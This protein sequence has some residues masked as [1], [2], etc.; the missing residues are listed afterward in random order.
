ML[1]IFCTRACITFSLLTILI[2]V[3][4]QAVEDKLW[5][6]ALNT[7]QQTKGQ[8][9]KGQKLSDISKI[10]VSNCNVQW[11]NKYEIEALKSQASIFEKSYGL[12]LRGGYTTDN[13][14]QSTDNI[15]GSTYLELSWDALKSGYKDY[16]YKAKALKREA[17]IEK[18][19]GQLKQKILKNECRRYLIDSHFSAM[20][21]YLTSLKL[22]FMEDIYQVER[23]AYFKGQSYLDELLI[24]EEDITLA[25]QRLEHINNVSETSVSIDELLN[26]PIINID[27]QKLLNAINEL[28]YFYKVKKLK[29]QQLSDKYAKE[30]SFI[31]NS[32]FRMFIRKE[33]DLARSGEDELVAGI[34]FQT[35]INFYGGK[36]QK[37]ARLNQLESDLNH[38]KWEI[39]TRARS[40]YQSL[41]EQL[42]RTIKQHYRLLRTQ[43]KVHRIERYAATGKQLEIAA[44]NVRVRSYL[45]AA[46]E[47]IDAKEELYRRVNEVFLAARVDYDPSY[48]KVSSDHHVKYRSRLGER[49]VYLWSDEFNRY[50]NSQ[51]VSLIDAKNISS[52]LL[53]ASSKVDGAKRAQFIK[54]ASQIGVNVTQ[55]IGEPE[56]VMTANHA[57]A[58][59]AIESLSAVHDRVHLDIE[60]H[61][62]KSYPSNSTKLLNQYISLLK[63]IR[64]RHPNLNISISVPYHW[65]KSVYE[66]ASNYVDQIYLMAYGTSSLDLIVNRTQMLLEYIPLNKL[67]L[68]VRQQEIKDELTLEALI[69]EVS[70]ATGIE[71]YATHKLAIYTQR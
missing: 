33:F 65:E 68:A 36:N 2:T 28:D 52:V 62:L 32:R 19:S 47:M 53:T 48:I 54:D 8:L 66:Q 7:F 15:D 27:F 45:D 67:V 44:V 57:K 23:Q 34:R 30:E 21:A 37:H 24:S 61:T 58:L 10:L 40:A 13:I 4:A 63:E 35:P 31:D 11:S 3:K 18:L 12:E 69:Q 49:S 46:L 64:A 9:A 43:E 1:S 56:W 39:I 38:E 59:A 26:P 42:E 5:A 51:L 70:Q 55:L 17:A 22:A 20:Q 41:Q 29:S 50:S 14:E 6:N 16:K 25:R 60:P 71:Q